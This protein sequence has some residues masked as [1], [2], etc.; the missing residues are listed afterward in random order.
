MPAYCAETKSPH[1]DG[2]QRHDKLIPLSQRPTVS[3]ETAAELSDLSKSSLY[4]LMKA[5]R[6]EFVKVGSRRL[7]RVQSLLRLLG[8]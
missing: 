5:G 6:L 7:I 3:M 8:A 4:K 2:N 1:S